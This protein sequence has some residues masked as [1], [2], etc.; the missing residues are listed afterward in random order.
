MDNGDPSYWCNQWEETHTSRGR[1]KDS[2]GRRT[3]GEETTQKTD[4]SREETVKT[5]IL[6][7]PRASLTAQHLLNN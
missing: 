4:S 6:E 5:N 2:G 1:G 7:D 3:A